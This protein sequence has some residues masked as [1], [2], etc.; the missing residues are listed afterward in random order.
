MPPAKKTTAKKKPAELNISLDNLSL[1]DMVA[2]EQA[3]GK[4]FGDLFAGGKPTAEG[5]A[6]LVY[7]IQKRTDPDFT[8]EDALDIEIDQL[9]SVAGEDPT[10]AAS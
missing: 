8:F 2:A 9:P 5:I 4:A 7:A 10:E 3:T 1:R 6:A